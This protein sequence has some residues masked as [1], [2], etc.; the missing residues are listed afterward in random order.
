MIQKF[1]HQYFS[2]RALHKHNCERRE[3]VGRFMTHKGIPDISQLFYT[4]SILH[5][6]VHKFTIKCALQK[7]TVTCTNSTRVKDFQKAGKQVHK[8]LIQLSFNLR[9]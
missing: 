2:T 7:K 9:L 3:T 8:D 4:T 5:S 1:R 6:K